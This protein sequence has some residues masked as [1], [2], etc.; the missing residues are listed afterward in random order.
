MVVAAVS[1]PTIGI[2]PLT[3]EHPEG[4]RQPRSR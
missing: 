4:D 1:V 2:T 3:A